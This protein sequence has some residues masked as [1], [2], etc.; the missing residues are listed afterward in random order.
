MNNFLKGTASVA[1]VLIVSMAI[2]VFCNMKGIS[3]DTVVTA[4]VSASFAISI[5]HVW[6]KNK[7][8]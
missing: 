8:Q 1:I 4:V 6:T 3:L 5:Y 7:D 2:H